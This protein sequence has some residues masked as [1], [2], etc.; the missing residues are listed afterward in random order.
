[1]NK[2]PLLSVEAVLSKVKTLPPLPQVVHELTAALRCETVQADRI[3]RVIENDPALTVT[4]LRLANSSFYGVSGRVVTLRDA[5]QILGVNTLSSAVMTA[6]VM[7]RFD[8]TSCPGFDFDACWRHAIAT[9]LCAQMLAQPRGVEADVA[10]T[11]GLLHDIGRLALATYFPQP[12]AQA[13]AWGAE[14]DVTPL[15]AEQHTLGIDHAEVGGM[16]AD[17]W[18]LAPVVALA[19]RAHHQE[20]VADASGLIDVLHLADNITHAL[21]LSA[22]PDDMVPPMSLAA[23]ERLSPSRAE[24]QQLFERIEAR[25][26]WGAGVAAS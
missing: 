21:D 16:L 3:V 14:H 11:A 22:T 17:H 7:S 18:R 26:A 10:Y 4:A 12:L 20:H 9:A 24:L 13:I 19:I 25:V 2:V 5:V 23:W 1:M 6:A 8:R 15:E